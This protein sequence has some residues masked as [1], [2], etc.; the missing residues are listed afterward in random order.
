MKRLASKEAMDSDDDGSFASG[1]VA[2]DDDAEDMDFEDQDSDQEDYGF[3]AE[4][5]GG[6]RVSW[7]GRWGRSS[8]A[9]PP[10]PSRQQQWVIGQPGRAGLV[11]E[12]LWLRVARQRA[13]C[14]GT[15]TYRKHLRTA[16][17]LP[18]RCPTR[19]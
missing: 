7:R 12:P 1:S 2:S 9:R 18:G 4:V 19:C 13:R 15:E 17:F 16:R 3:G 5:A 10:L 8:S 14:H 6:P 11:Q